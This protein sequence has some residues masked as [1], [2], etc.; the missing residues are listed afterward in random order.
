MVTCVLEASFGGDHAGNLFCRGQHDLAEQH[1]LQAQD[2]L[3]VIQSIELLKGLKEVGVCSLVVLLLSMQSARL[4]VNLRLQ[5]SR[6]SQG[7][8][9]CTLCKAMSGAFYM[10]RCQEVLQRCSQTC[11][12]SLIPR[13]AR[14]GVCWQ[15][16]ATKCTHF[17]LPQ[18]T[19]ASS[20]CS[21]ESGV[22]QSS[23]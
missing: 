3:G 19:S 17:G 15:C 12:L 8:V 23:R 13:W 2:S 11:R 14:L 9:G 10:H 7:G 22:A 1:V 5:R 16:S 4:G 6:G 21:N 18:A 20:P